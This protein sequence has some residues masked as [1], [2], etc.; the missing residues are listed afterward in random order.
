M[1]FDRLRGSSKLLNRKFPIILLLILHVN[2]SGF[3]LMLIKFCGCPSQV[4]DFAPFR[5]FH[6]LSLYCAF[7]WRLP[8][9][10]K[11]FVMSVCRPSVCPSAR[12]KYLGSQR[13][14]FHEIRYL[15]IFRKP[16]KIIKVS[17]N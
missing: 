4:L 11:S 1:Q 16:S 14:D 8:K 17:T 6:Y 5:N 3:H 15:K 13:K 7:F 2:F 12:R 10:V 9:I